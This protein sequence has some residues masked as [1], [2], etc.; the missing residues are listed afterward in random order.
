MSQFAA[1]VEPLTR[2]E[3]HVLVLVDSG[4][5]N[6]EIAGALSITVGTVKCTLT[7]CTRSYR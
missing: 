2:T 4:L 1:G 7:A 3:A 5:S 6:R